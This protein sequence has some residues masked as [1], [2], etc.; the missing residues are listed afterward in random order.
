MA[1][2]IDE[3][4]RTGVMPPFHDRS[5]NGYT[6]TPDQLRAEVRASRLVLESLIS[7]EGV[8]FALSDLDDRWEDPQERAL[9]LEVLR[10]LEAVPELL[11]VGPHLLATTRK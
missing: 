1:E 5:F 3:M 8:A 7:V 9:L 10:A 4:E 6:H 11:G 2:L